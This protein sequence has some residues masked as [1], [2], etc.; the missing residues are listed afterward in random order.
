MTMKRA[1]FPWRLLV[2]GIVVTTFDLVWANSSSAFYDDLCFAPQ[3]ADWKVA[4]CLANSAPHCSI[5]NDCVPA[6]CG[7]D[8]ASEKNSQCTSP[9]AASFGNGEDPH[10]RSMIHADSI[11]LLAQAVGLDGRAAYFIAA[12]GDTPDKA[13]QFILMV[14]AS[15]GGYTP[16]TDPLHATIALP[17]LFRGSA[18]GSA[19]HFPLFTGEALK[20][21]PDSNHEGVSRLRSWALGDGSGHFPPPC[22]GG[23]TF[24]SHPAKSYFIGEKCYVSSSALGFEGGADRVNQTANVSL[25]GD[26][27]FQSGDQPFSSPSSAKISAADKP[28]FADDLQG[29]LDGSPARFDGVRPVP[30]ALLKMGVYLHSLMDRVSHAPALT[31]LTVPATSPSSDFTGG[32]DWTIPH[33]YLHFE[34]VGIPTLSSRT[35]Q[36][37]NLA[38][39]ELALFAK[40]NAEFLAPHPVITAK[41]KV[42]P[43]LINSVLNE[44]AAAARLNA[45]EKL[46]RTLG[47]YALT[48]PEPI[49]VPPPR[50]PRPGCG[51]TDS[52][53]DTCQ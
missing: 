39:D 46:S 30:L 13:G 14:S 44:R 42:V 19:I 33:P 4:N 32:L 17:D 48:Q 5:K 10:A 27:S 41:S 43:A 11:Y 29:L 53:S 9:V 16:Y 21:V 1:G 25:S 28:V 49:V 24:P 23:L 34:E 52:G 26:T 7:A 12:Y 51:H 8:A 2:I 47:Y 40:R 37:L 35:E 20:I 6:S 3:G 36:A 45:L 38:Y 50:P 22:I 15:G 18:R 31:P